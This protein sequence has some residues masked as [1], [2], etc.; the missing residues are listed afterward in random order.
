VPPLVI[1][2]HARTTDEQAAVLFWKLMLGINAPDVSVDVCLLASR[3]SVGL[4]S[5]NSHMTE[6]AR[7]DRSNSNTFHWLINRTNRILY[8]QNQCH[9]SKIGYEFNTLIPYIYVMK[10]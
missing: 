1:L 4:I 3:Y 7:L 6:S 9:L 5:G 2:T 10:G 8:V